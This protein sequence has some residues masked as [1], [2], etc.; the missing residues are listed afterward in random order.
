MLGRLSGSLGTRMI[1]LF[2][3][4]VLIGCLALGLVSE[5]RAGSALEAEAKEAML[6]VVKQAA[7]TVDSRVQARMYVVES[8]A[9]RNVI[10]GI[11]GDHEAT[12][13]EKLEALR[14]EQKRAES[15]GFK[16]F[17]I[18][19][20]YGNAFFSDGSRANIADR[21]YFKAALGGRT[22]VSSTLVSKLD[23]SIVFAFATPVR[24]YA[25]N[26]ITGVLIGVMDGTRL[27]QLMASVTYGRTGYATAV[28]STGKTIGHKDTERVIS[29]ENILE[30]AKSNQALAPLAEIVSKMA[31]GEEGVATYTFQG[32]EKLMAYA[33]VKTTG[34]SIAVTAPK[35]EVLEKVASLKQSVLLVS[36]L[37]ILVA[38]ALTFVMTRTITTPI[39]DLTRIVKR[40]AE[41]DFRFD[42]NDKAAQH[43][44]RKD[45]I[46]QIANALATMQTNILSLIKALRTDAQTLSSNSESLSAASEE[47][48]SSSDEV[49]K[50]IQQVA[51]GASEQATHLQEILELMGN[52]TT[53]LEKVYDELG[54]VKANSEE[55]SRLADTGKKELDTLIASINDVREAF[56]LVVEKLEALKGSVEQVGEIL[57]VI[58][59]IADQ[60]NLLALNAAIEA[61]RAGEAGRGFAVVADEVRKLA[62]QSRASSDK[63]RELLN[64]IA[65]ETNEVVATSEEV[66]RQV[67]SQLENVE[68]TVKAFDDILDSVAAM[69]PM[70]ES[71]YR[72]MD[73]TVK[74][75][76]VVLDRVQSIS[77]VSEETSA[78][79]EEISASAEELSAS[80]QE[81]AANAQQVLEVAK[82]LE[83]Q[84]ERF[85]V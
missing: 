83:E 34:W 21:D 35:T 56:R 77:A 68:H 55:T 51:S 75:K 67:A 66:T 29:E 7:E 70:I 30:Q 36:I 45:E 46:G 80:T 74:A 58:N 6:K 31:K 13:E 60:T 8:I 65:S 42:E 10:R 43:L 28:D 49:A 2:G 4:I 39:I 26:E 64:S 20:K 18:T 82:R 41:Y 23:N 57:E 76:D 15:L 11:Q 37:I 25:T 24:H 81:I 27:S 32:Q 3:L 16:Q 48:A 53:S 84:V 85:K 22:V 59:G 52:I 61:A 73:S 33:P 19:D 9:N 50:A 17:G 78:S 38:L 63:I 40:F 54:R 69:A 47:I 44:K 62:E 5:D 71:T 1:V 12:L 72:E 14:D 79:S